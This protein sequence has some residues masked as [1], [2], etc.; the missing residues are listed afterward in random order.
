M[1]QRMVAS[2][3]R[4]KTSFGLNFPAPVPSIRPRA[5]TVCTAQTGAAN[6][7]AASSMAKTLF[8]IRFIVYVFFLCFLSARTLRVNQLVDFL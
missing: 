8:R 6:K 2:V 1:R 3:A 5:V 4:V 7:I